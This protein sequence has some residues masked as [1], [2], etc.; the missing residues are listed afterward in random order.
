LQRALALS[1]QACHDLLGTPPRFSHVALFGLVRSLLEADRPEEARHWIQQVESHDPSPAA[2]GTLAFALKRLSQSMIALRCDDGRELEDAL[3][4]LDDVEEVRH[5]R[6]TGGDL[7]LSLLRCKFEAFEALGQ[8]RQALDC[9]REWSRTKTQLRA[10]LAR[11][12][13][14]WA[15]ETMADLR[16]EANAFVDQALRAPLRMARTSLLQLQASSPACADAVARADHSVRRAIEIANQYLSVVRAEHLRPEDL[17]DVDLS[18]LV[19][20]VCDQ[21]AP[22]EAQGVQL[23]REVERRIVVRGDRVLLMRALGNLLSNALKHSPFGSV[24]SVVLERHKRHVTLAV[25][26]QGPGMPLE[27]RA[28]IFQRFATGAVRKGNG[29]GLAMVARVARV[30]QARITVDSEPGR[31]TCVVIALGQEQDDGVR[32]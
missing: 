14:Q 5:P 4:W 3:T 27:M 19:D 9:Q 24:V 15:S 6:V 13:G 8:Y 21:M 29:L 2:R 31:G 30:H 20:D 18:A 25:Q 10:S 32:A 11:E 23:Q 28:R 16:S 7:R 22:P 1:E 26:D 12:H 17:E